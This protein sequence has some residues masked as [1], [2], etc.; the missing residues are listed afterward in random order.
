MITGAAMS[1]LCFLCSDLLAVYLLNRPEIG[2]YVKLASIS[3][4]FQTLYSL[5]Y[6][7]FI[8]LDRAERSSLIKALMSIVKA[9]TA[10]HSSS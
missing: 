7:A 6:Y 9:S 4:L 3:I 1:L 10:P 8:G 2:F 5:V